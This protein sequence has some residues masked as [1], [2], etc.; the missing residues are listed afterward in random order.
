MMQLSDGRGPTYFREKG[1]RISN[2][3]TKLTELN[4]WSLY[5]CSLDGYL[6]L[7]II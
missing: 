4:I 3:E 7:K 1:T 6:G 2:H 5:V